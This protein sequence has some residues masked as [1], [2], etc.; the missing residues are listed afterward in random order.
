[1]ESVVSWFS[2]EGKISTVLCI[3][4]ITGQW[5]IEHAQQ[6]LVVNLSNGTEIADSDVESEI[7]KSSNLY[8][9]NYLVKNHP[10]AVM[11]HGD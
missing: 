6:D 11:I 7:V 1:M 2:R 4:S 9:R 8:E 5:Y 10:N 3:D